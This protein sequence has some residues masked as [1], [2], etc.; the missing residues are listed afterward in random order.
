[1]KVRAQ[2][3][4]PREFPLSDEELASMAQSAL[5][6]NLTLPFGAV[7]ANA[8][9]GWLT[10]S[11]EVLWH[12]QR[13]DAEECVRHL[14]GLAGFSNDITLRAPGASFTAAHES[15]GRPG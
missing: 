12:Y 1:M 2:Q 4:R 14:P 5:S 9:A 6:W 13:Q 11:G 10:L 8:S 7:K 3:P 15:R